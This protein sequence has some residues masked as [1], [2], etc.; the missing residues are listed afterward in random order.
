MPSD[1]AN[2]VT[3]V[4]VPGLFDL[5]KLVGKTIAV[6]AD[7]FPPQWTR[8]AMYRRVESLRVTELTLVTPIEAPWSTAEQQARLR[9]PTQFRLYADTFLARRLDEP[10]EDDDTAVVW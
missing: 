2:L 6:R 5:G 9:P 8:L 3:L 1:S 7:D 4:R 10:R